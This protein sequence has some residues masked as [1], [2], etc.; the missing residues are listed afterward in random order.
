MQNGAIVAGEKPTDDPSLADD[1]AEFK[2][3]N[4]AL[5]GS[6][7]G[8]QTVGKGKVYAGQNAEAV[9]KAMTVAPDF[10]HT[11]PQSDTR[12]L[13]VHRKLADSD[14]YF[15]DNRNERD[16]TVDAS[17]RITGKAPELWHAE[18]GEMEPASYTIANGRTTV[19]LH[20]EPWGT[21]F[22]VFRKATSETSHKLPAKVET[23]VATVKGPWNVAFQ[24]DRGAPA[25]VT[26]DNLA[27]WNDS[28]DAGVKYFSGTGTYTTSVQ[29]SADWFKPGTKLWINLGDVKNLAEVTVNGKS[30]GQVW[31]APY[32]VDAT[33]ALKPGANQV[34]IKVTNAWVNRLIGDQQPDAKTKYTFAD[35]KPYKAKSPLLP[36]GLMGPVAISAVTTK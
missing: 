11:K 25:T 13:F 4:D 1:Q 31:H 28:S 33:S 10:D 35:V 27:S 9:L 22:V 21:V 26:M 23:Q 17:F 24:P 34:T 2:K 32:R 8:V 7:S 3:I 15:V 36:S 19:P 16:E 20:L 18:T 29:A 5:F 14:I 30:L 12:V 6:G